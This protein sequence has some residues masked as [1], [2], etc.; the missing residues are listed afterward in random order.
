MPTNT[1]TKPQSSKSGSVTVSRRK[2]IMV[3]SIA[4]AVV[5][6]VAVV[7]TVLVVGGGNDKSQAVGGSTANGNCTWTPF[8]LPTKNVAQ[9]PKKVPTSGIV[10]IDLNTSLGAITFRMDRAKAPCTVASFV[11]LAQQGY[12]DN[13][14][15]HR[16]TTAGIW[17]VQCGDPSG[18]GT[19]NPGYF[20]PDE[21]TGSETYPAGTLAMARTADANSGGSQFFIVYK[22]SPS[23]I[24]HLGTL[25]YT[26]FGT[27]SS[28]LGVVQKVGKAGARSGTDGR[29]KLPLQILKAKVA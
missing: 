17:V 15:C 10:T 22:D 18:Y 21:A 6:V 13:S 5:V 3:A 12:F 2:L 16:V 26:V 4:L 28:G 27:V 14:P 11:S 1:E 23:L 25:Q 9:P 8:S 20:I 24:R 7:I 19:G 29:P